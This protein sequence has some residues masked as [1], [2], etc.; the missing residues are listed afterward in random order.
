MLFIFYLWV[1][2]H[3]V[4]FFFSPFVV[5]LFHRDVFHITLFYLYS[6]LQS[7]ILIAQDRF[8]TLVMGIFFFFF[9]AGFIEAPVGGEVTAF[10]SES[11][12]HKLNQF[13]QKH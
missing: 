7:F 10:M 4:A 1:K 8:C 3:L 9:F 6:S 11:L 12:N 5:Q 2:C 13:V